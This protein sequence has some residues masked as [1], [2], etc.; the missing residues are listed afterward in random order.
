M[1]RR[2]YPSPRRDGAP[3]GPPRY[4]LAL[5]A[6]AGA[7]VV[8]TVMLA[9]LGPAIVSWPLVLRT[10]VVSVTMVVA[11]TWVIMPRLTR[12]FGGWLH[13]RL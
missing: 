9:V 1:R 11:L 13:A 7:Y 12:L 5:L 10:F 8:I 2:R 6:W 4:K 3:A